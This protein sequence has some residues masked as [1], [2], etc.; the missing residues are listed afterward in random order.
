M[1]FTLSRVWRGSQYWPLLSGRL[2][3]GATTKARAACSHL[4]APTSIAAGRLHGPSSSA[5]R[6]SCTPPLQIS[7]HLQRGF[8]TPE[9]GLASAVWPA[10]RCA[11]LE[12]VCT[13]CSNP[14][15][16]A[17]KFH[18]RISNPVA[19]RPKLDGFSSPRYL[20]P[21]PPAPFF[22]ASSPHPGI[23]IASSG[24]PGL[25]LQFGPAYA[26]GCL[27]CGRPGPPVR[28]LRRQIPAGAR[29]LLIAQSV[30][31]PSLMTR[32]A[33][34]TLYHLRE[35]SWQRH[36]AIIEGQIARA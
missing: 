12:G 10:M 27:I 11:A 28:Q 32:A 22:P 29:K 36:A 16:A 21:P 6:P 33:T 7:L 31:A 9:P 19:G 4:Q 5:I 14:P 13:R 18:R 26:V 20:L 1:A 3:V 15:R 25:A 24:R 8:P 35:T 17:V 2:G 23:Q 30:P 34:T